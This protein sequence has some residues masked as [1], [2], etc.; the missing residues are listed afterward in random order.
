MFWHPPEFPS[1]GFYDH[2][3]F[4]VYALAHTVG[5]TEIGGHQLG[6]GEFFRGKK[7]KLL[8]VGC[9]DGNFLAWAKAAG[10]QVYGLDV[11]EASVKVARKVSPDIWNMHLDDFTG[12]A[13]EHQLQ[14]DTITLF[15]TLEHQPEPQKVLRQVF[16]LLRP[17]GWIAGTV[18]NRERLFKTGRSPREFLVDLPPHHFLWFNTGALANALRRT[19]FQDVR[20]KIR[21]NGYWTEEVLHK[22]GKSVKENIVRNKSSRELPLERLKEVGLRVENKKMNLMYLLRAVKNVLKLAPKGMEFLVEKPLGKG[23]SLYFEG[24]RPED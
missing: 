3:E 12:Y 19:G 14:F 13:A 18:P 4:G 10:H 15:E 20:I 21:M 7:G 9:A 16:E 22:L 24:R 1:Q 8:D 23:A 5:R 17:G 11:D 6:F 2:L